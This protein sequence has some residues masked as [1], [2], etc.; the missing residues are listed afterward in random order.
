MRT[1]TKQTEIYRF[2][3]LSESAKENAVR[4]Y[5]ETGMDYEWHDCVIEDAKEIG[6]ILG[7]DIDKVYFSGF[8]S[9]GDGACFDGSYEYKKGSCKAIRAEATTDT[10]LHRI[11]D[12]LF[13]AQARRFFGLSA[14]V[15][16]S[17]HYMHE[18]CTDVRAYLRD[19]Y[20]YS[21]DY[22]PVEDDDAITEALRDFMRWIYKSLE[23]QYE[24]EAST[25][26]VAELS[27]MNGWEYTEDGVLY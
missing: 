8:W 5:A 12:D 2:D 4:R 18:M 23:R 9:Q 17:G 3:E 19:P 13:S 22:A 6:K 21:D 10:E 27:E 1:A 7:I 11:A 14:R 15:K 24:Y 26:N 25:E 16:Q 20:G